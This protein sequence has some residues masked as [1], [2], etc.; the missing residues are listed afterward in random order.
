VLVEFDPTTEQFEFYQNGTTLDEETYALCELSD[1]RIAYT[2]RTTGN[3]GGTNQGA[4][5]IFLGIFDP[6]TETSDYYSTGS[7]LDDK[8]VNVHDLGNNTLAVVY[9]SYGA[10]GDQV[11]TGSEDVGVILFNYSTDTWGNAYQTGSATSE[12]FQQNGNP[13]ALISTNQIAITASTAGV[14]ADS[15]RTSGFL[16]VVLA[17]LDISAGTWKKYQVGSGAPDF[18]SSIFAAGDRLIIAGFTEATFVENSHGIFVEF[19]TLPGIAAKSSVP[20]T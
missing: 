1:G 8:G 5:D 11:N 2:G 14:F 16:D 6:T 12:I 19:D 18:S 10:L 7:G 13:S 9:G 4:Y 17:I 15:Q 20:E 3:L